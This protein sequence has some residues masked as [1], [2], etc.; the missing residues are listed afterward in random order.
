MWDRWSRSQLDGG[1]AGLVGGHGQKRALGGRQ[2]G[3]RNPRIGG[4]DGSRQT[5][6]IIGLARERDGDGRA[7]RDEVQRVGIGRRD[8][9]GGGIRDAVGHGG[10]GE[11]G[12]GG[13]VADGVSARGGAASGHRSADVAVAGSG[14]ERPAGGEIAQG[15]DRLGHISDRGLQFAKVGGFVLQ[16]GL[17]VLQRRDGDL[18]DLRGAGQDA[19]QVRGVITDSGECLRARY[20]R[21]IAGERGVDGTCSHPGLVVRA[22]RC[23]LGAKRLHSHTSAQR[24]IPL[25]ESGRRNG[26]KAVRGSSAGWRWLRFRPAGR[27]GTG[28]PEC[29]WRRAGDRDPAR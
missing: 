25:E 19:L 2:D 8:G 10:G 11:R 4:V 15:G 13:D 18:S 21:Q 26:E 28:W 23:G 12:Q 3:R 16:G 29:R 5:V 27:D 22:R 9:G 14:R 1:G 17:V 24:R 6:Q 7:A 20:G